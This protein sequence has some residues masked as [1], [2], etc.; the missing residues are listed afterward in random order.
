MDPWLSTCK[1]GYGKS[2][3]QRH[4][5]TVQSDHLKFMLLAF[6]FAKGKVHK[7]EGKKF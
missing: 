3:L 6:K 7:K 4:N 5:V 1:T 2:L